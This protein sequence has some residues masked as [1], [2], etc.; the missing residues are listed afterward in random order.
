[1]KTGSNM[2]MDRIGVHSDDAIRSK[3]MIWFISS[4]L[5]SLLFNKLEPLRKVNRTDFT[6]PSAIR[7]L[8]NI[9]V[10]KIKTDYYAR[11]DV[12]DKRQN[13]I[14]EAVKISLKEIDEDSKKISYP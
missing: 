3:T 2:G 12:L 8:K 1:M 14:L 7:K 4:I 10:D 11:S 13:Q 9:R 6:I 5:Y